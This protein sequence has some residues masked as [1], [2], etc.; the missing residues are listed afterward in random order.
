MKGFIGDVRFYDYIN[1]LAKANTSTFVGSLAD[2]SG[3]EVP[4]LYVNVGKLSNGL[5]IIQNSW[6]PLLHTVTAT[7]ANITYPGDGEVKIE[8]DNTGDTL[9]RAICTRLTMEQVKEAGWTYTVEY[10]L[11]D[12]GVSLEN[13]L[14]G[15]VDFVVQVWTQGSAAVRADAAVCKKIDPNTQVGFTLSSRSETPVIMVNIEFKDQTGWDYLV[16]TNHGIMITGYYSNAQATR[17][18]SG[19]ASQDG[20]IFDSPLA[21]LLAPEEEP[22]GDKTG[23]GS[24]G[25]E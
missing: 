6:K 17:S 3:G 19:T 21:E 5:P 24:E 1:L 18:I 2:V 13:A 14:A 12:V 20:N 8:I 25:G 9:I 23:D 11:D 15:K 22:E 16:P 10:P 7:G 4:T